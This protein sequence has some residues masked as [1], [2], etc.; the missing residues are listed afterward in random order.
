[1][2]TEWQILQLRHPGVVWRVKLRSLSGK[3]VYLLSARRK[4][5]QVE[6]RLWWRW[7]NRPCHRCT[8]QPSSGTSQSN[9]RVLSWHAWRSA[10]RQHIP[11][12]H[13]VRAFSHSH[14][15]CTEEWSRVWSEDRHNCWSPHTVEETS[16]MKSQLYHRQASQPALH[17][18]ANSSLA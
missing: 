17:A 3:G 9:R 11:Q 5:C 8:T 18:S 4:G 6:R 12:M 14:W 15:Y 7:R 16:Q 10:P 1:L 2:P 13:S